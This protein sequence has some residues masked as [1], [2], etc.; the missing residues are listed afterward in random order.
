[1]FSVINIVTFVITM[2]IIY[3]IVEICKQEYYKFE[4]YNNMND[5]KNDF[6]TIMKKLSII[7]A[8]GC[9]FLVMN[10]IFD[11]PKV[12]DSKVIP[13]FTYEDDEPY[14]EVEYSSV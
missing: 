8:T 6:I 9:L 13:I 12:K 10:I 1:M 2:Y 14:K 11:T 5:D 4:S 7:L 3:N